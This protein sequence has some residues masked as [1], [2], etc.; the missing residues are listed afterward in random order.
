MALTVTYDIITKYG[1]S[2]CASLD[3]LMSD[4]KRD[5]CLTPIT[6][7]VKVT[8]KDIELPDFVK[9]YNEKALKENEKRG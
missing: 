6:R 8:R 7:I 4:L 9:E 5:R 3:R 1:R 2:S